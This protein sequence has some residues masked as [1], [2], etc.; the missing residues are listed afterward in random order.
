MGSRVLRLAMGFGRLGC[1]CEMARMDTASLFAE[2]GSEAL[3]LQATECKGVV[4]EALAAT[5]DGMKCQHPTT[6]CPES[7]MQRTPNLGFWRLSTLRIHQGTVTTNITSYSDPTLTQP[8]KKPTSPV[9]LHRRHR[10]RGSLACHGIFHCT[11]ME[12]RCFA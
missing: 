12:S 3:L 1:H 2:L 11:E 6:R 4:F 9:K 8:Q 10:L 7:F 5:V